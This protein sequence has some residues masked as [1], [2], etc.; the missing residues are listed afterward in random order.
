MEGLED[1]D[2][3]SLQQ[4]SDCR[5]VP[6]SVF[7][8]FLSFDFVTETWCWWLWRYPLS[9]PMPLSSPKLDLRRKTGGQSSENLTSLIREI[10]GV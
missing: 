7:L 8:L 6:F 4:Q 1:C 2:F 10:G 9:L 3:E 5:G